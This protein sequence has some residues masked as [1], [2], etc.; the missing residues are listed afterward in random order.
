MMSIDEKRMKIMNAMP[1]IE[2]RKKVMDLHNNEIE[3]IWNSAIDLR[4]M[5]T[6]K[7]P[8]LKVLA[9]HFRVVIDYLYL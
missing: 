5:D 1:T 6:Y 8:E 2:M 4:F 7:N 9:Y 3:T